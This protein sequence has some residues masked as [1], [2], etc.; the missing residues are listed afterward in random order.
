[1]P[2]RVYSTAAELAAIVLA[3]NHPSSDLAARERFVSPMPGGRTT[4]HIL[5]QCPGYTEQRRR[6]FDAYGRLRL[7]HVSL[8]Y[9]RFPQAHRSKLLLA[10]EALL[11]F[12]GNTDLITR[13]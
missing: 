8:D 2:I 3:A 10:F 1:M 13:L 11:D 12:F 4:E 9:L 7:P 6:L 5:L